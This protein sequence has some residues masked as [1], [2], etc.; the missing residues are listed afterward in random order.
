VPTTS[1]NAPYNRSQS[2][3]DGARSFSVG[4]P[5]E[6]RGA[7]CRLSAAKGAPTRHAQRLHWGSALGCAR[8]HLHLL[9]QLGAFPDHI[10]Q[11]LEIHEILVGILAD[12]VQLFHALCAAEHE[13]PLVADINP[14]RLRLG[15][16]ECREL[17]RFSWFM[18]PCRS[19]CVS[20]HELCELPSSRSVK[21]VPVSSGVG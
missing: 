3:I 12:I 13:L 15:R 16:R 9:P 1:L 2:M 5:S 21:S 14:R 6:G 7:L 8:S 18:A 10:F 4:W 19:L 20:D 17:G 11:E